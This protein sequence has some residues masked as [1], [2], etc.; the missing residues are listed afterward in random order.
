M[1]SNPKNIKAS[2]GVTHISQAVGELDE[3][4]VFVKE[5][6]AEPVLVVAHDPL[7]E[8]ARQLLVR[9]VLL[10]LLELKVRAGSKSIRGEVIR[11]S[12]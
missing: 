10:D 1:L 9:H 12:K 8:R 4:F 5:L 2:A 11:R 6:A 3:D 7:A